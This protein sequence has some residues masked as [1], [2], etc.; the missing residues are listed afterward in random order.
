MPAAPTF[1]SGL[2]PQRSTVAMA[3]TVKSTQA[4]LMMICCSSPA[5]TPVEALRLLKIVAPK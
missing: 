2:R 4:P 1:M 3:T 5:S